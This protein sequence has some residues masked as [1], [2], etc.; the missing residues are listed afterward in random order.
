MGGSV[1]VL[2]G[3]HEIMNMSGDLRYVQPAYFDHA[4]LLGKDYM[5]LF[6][7]N[8][9][10]GRWLRSKNII[11]KTGRFLCMHAGM[12]YEILN[13][14]L[15]LEA[16]NELVRPWYARW[17]SDLPGYLRIFLMQTPHFGLGDTLK[18]TGK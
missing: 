11:Q 14:K 5:Q 3:N 2:L 8:T 9:E 15:S 7:E 16:I 10:L 13:R 1:H 18:S 17:K 6:D 12:S 4:R